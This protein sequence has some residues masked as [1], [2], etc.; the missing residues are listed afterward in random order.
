MTDVQSYDLPPPHPPTPTARSPNFPPNLP[1]PPEPQGRDYRHLPPWKVEPLQNLKYIDDNIVQEK[2]NFDSIPTDGYSFRTKHAV[3]TQ[4]LTHGIV[5]EAKAR[6]LKVN[7]AKATALCIS[8][9]KNFIPKAF[10]Y[11][12]HVNQVRSGNEMKILGFHFSSDVG[13]AAQVQ[14]IRRKF[15]AK[16]WVRTHLANN[17]FT[18]NDLLQ[19]YK[20]TILPIHDY[21]SRVYNSSLTK[22]QASAL[23]RLQAHALKTIYGYQHSY[24]SL[25]ETVPIPP[26][27][28]AARSLHYF[29]YL[30]VKAL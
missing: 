20:A 24:R 18:Q 14:A 12:L 21:C 28:L 30:T 27:C 22:Q 9:V 23:E 10:T 25:L 4:N 19:V 3:R 15:F 11:D 29:T 17:G 1:V 16:K 13:M 7:N 5:H 8:E 6:G 2:L 26:L